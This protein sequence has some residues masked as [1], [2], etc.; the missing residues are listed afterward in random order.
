M[1]YV[2]SQLTVETGNQSSTVFA[3]LTDTELRQINQL[4][5]SSYQNRILLTVAGNPSA[6]DLQKANELFRR[7]FGHKGENLT[8]LNA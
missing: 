3:A 7:S 4:P 1:I 2:L 5:P 6:Q 8:G